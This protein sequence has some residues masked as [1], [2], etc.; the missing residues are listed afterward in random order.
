MQFSFEKVQKLEEEGEKLSSSHSS[1]TPQAIE[2]A[3]PGKKRPSSAKTS[4]LSKRHKSGGS[5][6]SKPSTSSNNNNNKRPFNAPPTERAPKASTSAFAS[7]PTP[8]GKGK[9]KALDGVK[10]DKKGKGP[11]FITVPGIKREK[12]SSDEED[13]EDGE[14]ESQ[15]E[16]E[17]GDMQVDEELQDGEGVEFL[18]KL[19]QKGISA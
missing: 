18:T 14:G 10:K 19:D 5:G 15:E 9:Y 17:D 6:G 13:S 7:A 2:S 3:M 12:N 8:G 4:A 1:I 11:A 16:S